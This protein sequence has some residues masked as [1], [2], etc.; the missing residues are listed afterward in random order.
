MAPLLRGH[1]DQIAV[2]QFTELGAGHD[3]GLGR[4]LPQVNRRF[5]GPCPVDRIY[6]AGE[7]A[8]Q[9]CDAFSAHLGL[10]FAV[11]LSD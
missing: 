11:T 2:Q 6:V 7:R 10:P 5:D 9:R 1:L 4:F 3:A 8:H